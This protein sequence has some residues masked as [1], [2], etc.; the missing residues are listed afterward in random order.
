VGL[1]PE[2][3]GEVLA[4]GDCL[5][6]GLQRPVGGVSLLT[7]LLTAPSGAATTMFT[8]SGNSEQMEIP[9]C[10]FI[11]FNTYRGSYTLLAFS[12]KSGLQCCC[13]TVILFIPTSYR[14]LLLFN[15]RV[16]FYRTHEPHTLIQYTFIHSYIM[17]DLYPRS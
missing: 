13:T 9:L 7:Y 12:L 17:W 6:L 11:T 16:I 5:H 3:P 14:L 2:C 8:F 1:G 10:P 15:A 4:M